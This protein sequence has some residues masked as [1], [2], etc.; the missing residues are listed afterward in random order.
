MKFRVLKNQARN[1][2]SNSW[3]SAVLV[4]LLYGI[5]NYL[6]PNGIEWLLSGGNM[7]PSEPTM[8]QVVSNIL[9][10]LL[11]PLTIGFTWYFM[12]LYNGDRTRWTRL[13]DPFDISN[14]LKMFG[15]VLLLW[16]YSFLWTLLFIV[17]GIIKSLA[18]SQTYFVMKDHPELSI[19]QAITRSREL[20][21][22]YKWKYFLFGLSFIG[23]FI[24]ACITLGIGFLWLVPYYYMSCVA[25]YRHLTEGASKDPEEKHAI[26]FDPEI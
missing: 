12:E 25:F 3:G 9:S 20:M 13:F 11:A 16:L 15:S 24:L 7:G 6:V 23:W 14:Y 18:Y 1:A 10:I 17:P 26:P 22:G 21:N 4:T 5:F 19:N 2:L 8:P